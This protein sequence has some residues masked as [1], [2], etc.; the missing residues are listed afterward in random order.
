M[1]REEKNVPVSILWIFDYHL[2]LPSSLMEWLASL[3]DCSS[4]L[5]G[6]L[7]N[8]YVTTKVEENSVVDRVA[9]NGSLA[10]PVL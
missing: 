2:G 7:Q 4:V 10:S 5:F 9:K 6:G 1:I 3:R 8:Y